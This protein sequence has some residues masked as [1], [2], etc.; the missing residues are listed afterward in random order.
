MLPSPLFIVATRAFCCF[1]DMREVSMMRRGEEGEGG[2]L[3]WGRTAKEDLMQGGREGRELG[4][5]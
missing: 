4:R 5:G 1:R 2:G 3:G